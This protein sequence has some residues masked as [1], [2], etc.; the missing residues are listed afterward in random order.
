MSEVVN[1]VGGKT[2]KLK[3]VG[4]DGNAFSV[5]G[6]FKRA[7]KAQGWDRDEITAVVNEAC[8]GDYDHLLAVISKHCEE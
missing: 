5:L 8:S 2:V 1:M 6:A 4:L 3:L 7:A